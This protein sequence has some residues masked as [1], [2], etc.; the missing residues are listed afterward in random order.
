MAGSLG[1]DFLL[2]RAG[3]GF[4]AGPRAGTAA[5]SVAVLIVRKSSEA[6]TFVASAFDAGGAGFTFGAV[7][8]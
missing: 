2:F 6:G 5:F 1:R 3:G 4:T 8:G 7:A